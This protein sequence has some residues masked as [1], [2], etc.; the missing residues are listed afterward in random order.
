MKQIGL[1]NRNS[2]RC[3]G[4]RKTASMRTCGGVPTSRASDL[5]GWSL[6]RHLDAPRSVLLFNLVEGCASGLWGGLARH[7]PR[8]WFASANHSAPWGQSASGAL[9]FGQKGTREGRKGRSSGHNPVT[10]SVDSAV[11][12]T[13]RGNGVSSLC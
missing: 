3:R 11:V 12:S 10:G 13:D 1:G 8:I 6:S 7:Q 9:L 2:G 4:H 5:I